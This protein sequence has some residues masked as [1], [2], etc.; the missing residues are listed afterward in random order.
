MIGLVV[1][2]PENIF[3]EEAQLLNEMFNR[4]L[5]HLHIRKPNCNTDHLRNLLSQ[6]PI[7]NCPKICL[8]YY[9][10]IAKEFNLGSIQ[11]NSIILTPP[12][13]W[14]GFV[15]SSCHSLNE[16]SKHIDNE[17][18]KFLSPIYNSISKSGYNSNFSPHNLALHK[19]DLTHNNVVALGGITLENIPE[20]HALG[21]VGFAILGALWKDKNPDKILE[22]FDKF[23][24]K[25][26]LFL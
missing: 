23:A 5:Q 6:I 1:I 21:F 7:E 17:Q 3:P 26:N 15:C 19:D 16:I 13:D 20:V 2:T 12:P 11:L 10:D 18:Y 25:S 9:P 8:H 4:G 22:N 24:E 14:T